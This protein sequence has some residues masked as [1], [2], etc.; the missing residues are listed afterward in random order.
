MFLTVKKA[1][2]RRSYV[3]TFCCFPLP[4]PSGVFEKSE[5]K[6]APK[7]PPHVSVQYFFITWKHGSTGALIFC[8]QHL[9]TAGTGVSSDMSI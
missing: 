3:N 7:Q 9:P 2:L 6:K 8:I 5:A 1:S 4:K